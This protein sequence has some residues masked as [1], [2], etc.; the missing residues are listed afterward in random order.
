MLRVEQRVPHVS[1]HTH[2]LEECKFRGI[3]WIEYNSKMEENKICIEILGKVLGRQDQADIFLNFEQAIEIDPSYSDAHRTLSRLI[4][5]SDN[6]SHFLKLKNLYKKINLDH[7]INLGFA[8]GKAYE[9]IKNYEKSFKFYDE[10]NSIYNKKTN[11]SMDREN[12]K[13]HKIKKTID[14]EIF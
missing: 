9:D 4:N 8:L 2:N 1:I 13:F 10:A 14:K 12:E 7:K 5:Y 3:H 6:N 11:F